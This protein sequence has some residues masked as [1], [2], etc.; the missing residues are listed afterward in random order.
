MNIVTTTT[1]LRRQLAPMRGHER[2]AFVPTMGCLHE[3]H[4]SLIRKAKKMADIV[5]VSIYVNPLQFGPNEDFNAYPRSFEQ[6]CELCE[7]EGVEVIFHPENLYPADGIKV[8]LKV[9]ELDSLL[10][11]TSRPGHFD[12]VVTVV[13]LLFNIVRPDI[14]VFGEKDYQQL[15]IINRMASDLHMNVEII[16]APTLREPDG[17]AMSSRNRYLSED[18]RNRASHLHETLQSMKVLFEQG[19][20]DAGRLISL[21]RAKL[22]DAGIKPEYLEIRDAQNLKPVEQLGDSPARIF[23]AA[24]IGNT[25]L[26]DNIA[27]ERAIH[28]SSAS[29]AETML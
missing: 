14:A 12:G 18:E 8:S 25:R 21:G 15:T 22:S 10:C 16:S 23:I 24:K 6:D 7:K 29:I 4:L 20:V 17:L 3:G 2:I 19:E 1:E 27:L 11:G 26:I 9:D 28:R 13:N 5:V